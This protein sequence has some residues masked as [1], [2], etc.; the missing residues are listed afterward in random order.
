MFSQAMFMSLLTCKFCTAA[1]LIDILILYCFLYPSSLHISPLCCFF[2]YCQSSS[3][4]C[5]N[6]I[7]IRMTVSS[8]VIWY[9]EFTQTPFTIYQYVIRL[10]VSL[11]IRSPGVFK[12]VRCGNIVLLTTRF[13]MWQ[14]LLF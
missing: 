7:L 13:L 8:P 3:N 14:S 10:V 12:N 1:N 2:T 11:S 9:I 6:Q 5:N 4:F